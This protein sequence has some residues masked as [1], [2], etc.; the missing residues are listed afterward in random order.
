MPQT[1]FINTTSLDPSTQALQDQITLQRQQQL[2]QMMQQQAMEP[3]QSPNPNAR[4]S[5]LQGL[6]KMLQGYYA[7]Q[8]RNKSDQLMV[9]QIQNQNA[10]LDRMF[11]LTPGGTSPMGSGASPA[12]GAAPPSSAPAQL[13]PPPADPNAQS[14]EPLIQRDPSQ[15]LSNALAQPPQGQPAQGMAPSA[16]GLQPS[17]APQSGSMLPSL[18]GDPRRDR[19]MASQ[20]GLGK[21]IELAVGQNTDLTKSLMAAGIDPKSQDG[22]KLILANILKQNYVAP[23]QTRE[24]SVVLDPNTHQPIFYNPKVPV[25]A[26]PTW[27]V[28]GYPTQVSS[29]T[30]APEAIKTTEQSE[31]LGK[32]LGGVVNEPQRGGGFMPR[33]GAQYFGQQPTPGAPPMPAP[34]MAIPQPASQSVPQATA[35][36]VAGG[37]APSAPQQPLAPQGPPTPQQ[38]QYW[39]GMPRYQPP[40]GAGA[41]STTDAEEAKQIVDRRGELYNTFG[42]GAQL[43]DERQ[44]NNMLALQQ[45]GSASTGPWADRAN[46]VRGVLNQFGFLGRDSEQAL[47]STTELGKYLNNN[48][49]AKAKQTFGG[50]RLTN[51][52]VTM[53]IEKLNPGTNMTDHAIFNLTVEDGIRAAYAKQMASDYQIAVKQG[54]DPRGFEGWY[55]NAHPLNQFAN[56]VG[57]QIATSARQAWGGGLAKATG[58]VPQGASAPL[59]AGTTKVLNGVIYVNTTGR[60][61]GWHVQQ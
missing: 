36:P 53:A 29:I 40:G 15:T 18:T 1:N 5:P 60:P 12:T 11:G 49:L 30:G 54:V 38:P 42:Q 51:T 4:M 24:G 41:Q 48:A 37:T 19:V 17:Q 20:L 21:Y 7:G 39:H 59:A 44:R 26:S 25:G 47:T 27:G 45:L 31:A 2:A 28:N 61:D 3:I 14:V 23:E 8:A 55:A 22:Q 9:G 52:D 56:Q 6:N 13:A 16:Q 46:T 34:Q 32:T 58:G 57:P 43:S 33:I 10:Q 50:G 35:S